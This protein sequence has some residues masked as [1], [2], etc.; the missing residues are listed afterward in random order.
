MFENTFDRIFGPHTKASQQELKDLWYLM[1]LKNGMR[2]F[3]LL[4][5]YMQD[6]IDHEE[7]WLKALQETKI[8]LRLIDGAYDPISANIL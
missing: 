7:R 8:P 5:R 1:N 3:H 2:I 4:I 6:R